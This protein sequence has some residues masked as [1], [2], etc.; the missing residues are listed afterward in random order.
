MQE[1]GVEV[2][3]FRGTRRSSVYRAH[4]V[5]AAETERIRAAA[6]R[7]GLPLLAALEPG[8]LDKREARRLADE[9]TRLRASATLLELDDTLTA[10][11]EVA[12]WC[13]R[14]SGRAWLRLD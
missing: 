11:A 1:P 13:A 8:E 3:A 9:L 4:A 5:G 14:A 12:S 2:R 7:L 6:G 10:L